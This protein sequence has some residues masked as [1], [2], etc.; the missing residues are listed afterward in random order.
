MR[1]DINL[2]SQPYEDARRF[3]TN[4]GTALGLLGFATLLLVFV[5]ATR[6]INANHERKEIADMESVIAKFDAEKAQA[7]ATLN[8]PQN[9][10]TRDRS[11]FLNE[12]FVRKAF[13][14]TRLFEDLERVMPAHLHVVRISP[15][16]SKDNDLEIKLVVG[17]DTR[18]QALDLVRK[19][20]RMCPLEKP[21]L[22]EGR[23][24]AGSKADA[25]PPQ[26]DN[27]NPGN[28]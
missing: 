10:L 14:W 13:S 3:W 28:C 25:Q 7:E 17:G 12:L 9:R 11:Q 21:A 2:A 4:W 18:E 22:R 16:L 1:I 8:R 15:D 6:L 26:I 5:A 27:G 24:D 20:R 19:M 23:I